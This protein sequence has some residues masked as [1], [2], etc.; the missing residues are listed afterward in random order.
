MPLSNITGRKARHH[1][2]KKEQNMSKKIK[3]PA[4]HVA[5]G[6]CDPPTVDQIASCAYGIWEK[7]G[8][9]H[10]RDREHWLQAE[11]QLKSQD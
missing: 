6:P 9:A 4:Q 11:M 2:T 10:G 5:D 1:K 7:E 8:R 3:T